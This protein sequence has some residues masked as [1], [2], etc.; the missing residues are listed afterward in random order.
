[1]L[2]AECRSV[3]AQPAG[4]GYSKRT[5]VAVVG[6]ASNPAQSELNRDAGGAGQMG[7]PVEP[8][9]AMTRVMSHRA[10]RVRTDT[11]SERSQSKL[12]STSSAAI[13]GV[14]RLNAVSA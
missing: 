5:M 2:V 12:G 13:S 4:P 14:G 7:L 3:A 6:L 1:M 8:K 11:V 9:S 10:A